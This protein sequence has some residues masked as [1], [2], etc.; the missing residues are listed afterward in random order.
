VTNWIEEWIAHR[1][2][3]QTTFSYEIYNLE[4]D[5]DPLAGREKVVQI[6]LHKELGGD[7]EVKTPAGFID[8][9]TET[10]VIEIKHADHW[11]HAVGQVMAYA[12][13]YPHHKK[14]IHL[15]DATINNKMIEEICR[16]CC[17]AVSYESFHNE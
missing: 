2:Q 15:F 8:L 11:K 14:R 3:N 4:P 6:R 9:L 16:T 7:M 1:D 10:E 13:F 5:R 17:I 12:S